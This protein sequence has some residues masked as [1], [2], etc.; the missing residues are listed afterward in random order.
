MLSLSKSKVDKDKAGSGGTALH[1]VARNNR[2][3]VVEVLLQSGVAKDAVTSDGATALHV[4]AEKG[5][6]KI[7]ELL[8]GAG[9]DKNKADTQ[10]NFGW[11]SFFWR[12]KALLQGVLGSISIFS[13]LLK[14]IQGETALHLAVSNGHQ[15][16]VGLLLEAGADKNMVTKDGAT[17]EHLASRLGHGEVVKLFLQDTET[18]VVED[19]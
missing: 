4:A 9:C 10:G 12:G 6:G 14:Q 2:C 1:W 8:L 3:Q 16:V 5:R 7:V 11:L 18:T 15:A 19:G 13:R 17:A